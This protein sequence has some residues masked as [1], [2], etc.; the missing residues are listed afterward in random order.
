M[1]IVLAYLTVILIWS[2]TPLA[3]QF[4]QQGLDFYTAVVL[5]MWCAALVS[6][7]VL[8]L[9]RQR[10]VLNRNALISYLAGSVGVYGAMMS[11]YWGSPY[12]PSGLVSVLYGLSPMLSGAIA[13]VWLRER[14]LTPVRVLALMIAL[15]G[16]AL[17]VSARLSVDGLAWR[18]IV[19]TLLSVLFFAWSAV[20]VKKANAGLH[21]MVQ[22]SG[23]LWLSS[24]FY[25]LT[26]PIFGL[27]IPDQWPLTSQIG[28]AYLVVFGSIVGFMLYFFILKY[29]SAARVTLITLVAPLLALTWGN[30]FNGETFQATSLQ[31]AALLLTGLGLYQ[32]HQRADRWLQQRLMLNR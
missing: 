28:L 12:I 31:G 23:T 8:W 17:V 3:I 26:L 22:T 11:V 1:V 2:T 7:P 16:L 6:L 24:L 27:H 25:L 4:S 5:R 15:S 13:Y 14:E 30:L 20:W 19:G 18:G 29:L 21:P 32:W 9:L 10:L